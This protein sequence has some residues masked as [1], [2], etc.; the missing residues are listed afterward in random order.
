MSFSFIPEQ[1][2]QL[3]KNNLKRQ[4]WIIDG[5]PGKQIIVDGESY[6]NFSSNDYLGLSQHPEIKEAFKKGV[7]TYGVGSTGSAVVTGY[8]RAHE[9]LVKRLCEWTCRD[10]ALLFNSGFAANQAVISGLLSKGDFLCED[11]LSHASLIDAGVFSEAEFS[12]FNH[13]DAKHLE[14]RLRKSSATNKLV[15]TEGVFSMDGDQPPLQELRAVAEQNNA[16]LMV[17]DAHGIGVLGNNGAGTLSQFRLS[18]ADCQIQMATFGKALGVSGAFVSGSEELIDYLTNK[19]RQ[20]IYSTAF[21]AAQAMA[22]SKAI[23]VAVSE[24]WRREKLLNL[25]GQFRQGATELGLTLMD[26]STAIQPIVI[27]AVDKAL[28]ISEQLKQ[29]GIWLTAIRPPTVPKG[30]ARLRIT[31]SAA[32]SEDEVNQ[33]LNALE[34]SCA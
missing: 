30:T 18:Q 16:W 4:H 14:I 10:A 33:L 23:Q 11:K 1:L 5:A 8:T 2:E 21:P 28:A 19:A 26:S 25:I 22:I 29:R 3:R 20:H 9:E 31:L 17:D 13:N 7:D 27:G 15:V 6:L 24:H 12:R 32:H 34:Q